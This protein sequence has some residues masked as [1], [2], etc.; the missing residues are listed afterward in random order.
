[1]AVFAVKLEPNILVSAKNTKHS[2]NTENIQGDHAESWK[3][4]PRFNHFSVIFT[5]PT[6]FDWQNNTDVPQLF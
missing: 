4:S 6:Q 5:V 1:M 2:Q 3:W